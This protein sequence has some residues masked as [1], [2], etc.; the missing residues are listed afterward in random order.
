[1]AEA[2]ARK[3]AELRADI[4]TTRDRMASTASG[5]EARLGPQHRTEQKSSV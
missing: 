3:A 1:M 5:V 2:D 4:A